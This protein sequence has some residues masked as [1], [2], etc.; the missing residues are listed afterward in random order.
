M[1]HKIWL[2][3]SGAFLLSNFSACSHGPKDNVCFGDPADQ[4]LACSTYNGV[5][6]TLTYPES[7]TY[8][9]YSPG[10]YQS[11]LDWCANQTPIYGASQC[12]SNASASG[13]DCYTL[14]CSGSACSKLTYSFLP[15]SQTNGYVFLS[16]S[17]DKTTKSYCG[18]SVQ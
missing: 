7:D 13:L 8:A 15:W 5:K 16:A 9:A 11:F 10:T 1:R 2:I 4:V 3:L 14:S 18:L 6:T 12:T 17:D